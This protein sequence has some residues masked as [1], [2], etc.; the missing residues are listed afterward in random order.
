MKK[1]DSFILGLKIFWV[2]SKTTVQYIM[3]R[4]RAAARAR[5]AESGEARSESALA[6]VPA[7]PAC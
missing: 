2:H 1:C 6:L 4:M 7:V 5:F 3:S